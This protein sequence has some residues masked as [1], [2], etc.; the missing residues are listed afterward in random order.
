MRSLSLLVFLA[1]AGS[2]TAAAL[3]SGGEPSAEASAIAAEGSFSFANSGDGMPIFSASEIAPGGSVSGTVEIAD[4]GTEPGELTL[5]Q[6]DIADV[7]GPGGGKLSRRMSLQI[8]DVTNPAHPAIVYSGPLAPMPPQ[9]A[10]QLQPGASRTYEFLATLPEAGAVGGTQNDV[11]GAS[12]SVAYSWTAAE[13]VATPEPTP[14]TA[15]PPVPTPGQPQSNPSSAPTS[16]TPAASPL[17]LAITRVRRTIQHGRLIVWARC[18]TA[19]SISAH[20]RLRALGLAGRD[21]AKLRL[22]SRSAFARGRQRLAI[23]I[24]HRLRGWLEA[25]PK[26]LRVIA[27]LTLHARD[28][29]GNRAAA[30]QTFRVR[31]SGRTR[32]R[33]AGR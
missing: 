7:P 26:P 31:L 19:C 17:R 16:S 18:D 21:R 10:G 4:T 29:A 33:A 8:T 30:Q 5:A 13:V 25:S 1:L 32:P 27:R 28:R 20:G 24:S 3:R 15:P 23:R 2:A 14:P 6:H 12:T 11:Q 9:P 22:T